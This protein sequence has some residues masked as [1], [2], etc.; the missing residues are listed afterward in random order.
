MCRSLNGGNRL[1]KLD[2]FGVP[3]GV[4][5][6][7]EPDHKT[8]LGGFI[9]IFLF[10]L[11]SSNFLLYLFSMFI[12]PHYKQNVENI[13]TQ[14]SDE[15]NPWVMYTENTTLAGQIVPSYEY[16]LPDG[17]KLEDLYRV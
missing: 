1:R 10:L 8:R 15:S 17:V 2:M 4:T 9:T 11:F 12:D 16:E 14:F 3:V 13:Y 5:F 7:G 6:K